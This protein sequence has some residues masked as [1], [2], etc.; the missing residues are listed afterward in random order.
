VLELLKGDEA[1]A[2][3]GV[4]HAVDGTRP[5]TE[6]SEPLLGGADLRLGEEV[7]ADW[8]GGLE[9]ERYGCE[10]DGEDDETAMR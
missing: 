8:T 1:L 5:I 9:R 6:I 3:H 7:L 2:A 10:K 4:P